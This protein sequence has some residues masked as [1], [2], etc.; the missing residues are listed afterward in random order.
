MFNKKLVFWSACFGL[1]LF[2]AGLITLGS[3]A[4]DLKTKFRLDDL[5]AGTLFSILPFGILAGS[6]LFGP[7]CDRYGYKSMLVI[8]CIAMFAGFE[9]IAYLS[10]LTLLQVCIFIFGAG[11]GII[12]GA[13]NAVVSD[14]SKGSEGA[15]LNLLGVFFGIGALG[16]PF[17]LAFL[18]ESF[19]SFEIVAFAGWLTLIVAIFYAFIKFPPS[20]KALGFENTNSKALFKDSYLYFIA[21]Y[22]FFQGSIEAIVN[23]WTTTYFTRHLSVKESS[24]LYALSLYVAGLT[25]TRL[26]IGGV[27]RSVKVATLMLCSLFIVLTGILVLH[28]SET[29]S[30][31]VAGLI[32]LGIGLAAGFPTMLGLAGNR[33]AARS[34][35]AFSIIFTIALFGNMLVNYLMG[36][37]SKKFG[38]ENLTWVSLLE[39]VFMLLFALLIFRSHNLAEKSKEP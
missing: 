21:F 6:L 23:N 36:F 33:Y 29:F 1:L 19:S 17:V 27:F 11:A 26:L 25:V 14:I 32:L 5:S 2:G 15:N 31:A 13:T 39:L 9:G 7:V 37:I 30:I 22:L 16:M 24:A 3:I 38:I 20:K 18:K 12:N 10:S 28:F 4:P 34:G 8:S 35:T